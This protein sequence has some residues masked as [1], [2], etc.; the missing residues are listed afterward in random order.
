MRSRTPGRLPGFLL[1]VPTLGSAAAAQIVNPATSIQSNEPPQSL[2][3]ELGRQRSWEMPATVVTGS[4]ISPLREEDLIG[5]YRQPRWTARRLFPTTRIYVVPAGQF[6]FEQWTR[7]KVP[8]EGSTTVET[9]YEAEIGLGGRWQLDLYLVNEKTGS[10]GSLDVS[11]QKFEVRY[12]LADWGEI[13]TNPTLYFE[14]VQRSAQDDKVEAKLLMGDE[15]AVGWHW[16]SNLVYEAE[17]G[18]AREHEYGL[19]L[20]VSHTI[21]DERFSLGGEMKAALVDESGS[22]G[23]FSEELEIGPSLQFRPVPAMHIDFAPLIGVGPDSREADIFL[24]LGW[25]F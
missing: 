13:S 10:E 12:A 19:T 15:L 4:R 21:V 14:Y 7:I 25:E 5:S 20:G 2:D 3:E 1:A 18:G 24:V 22:R 11:E 16:G 9:Q 23:D 17:L 8:K 6:E